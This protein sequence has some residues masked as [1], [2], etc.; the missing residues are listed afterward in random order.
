M[1]ASPRAGAALTRATAATAATLIADDAGWGRDNRPVINVSWHDAKEYAGWLSQK[2]GKTY[3]LL[4][5]AEWEYA[6]RAGSTT[7]FWWGQDVGKG[8]A[9]CNGCG[10]VWDHIK[11][12]RVGSFRPNDFGLYDTAGNVGEWVE[13]CSHDTSGALADRGRDRGAPTDGSP[14]FGGDCTYRDLRG[15]SWTSFPSAVRSAVHYQYLADSWANVNG[16]RVARAPG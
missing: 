4:S 15:G 10:S 9:N 11:T 14:W 1:P 16:F 6:A 5:A 7:A 12:A 13:D 3:R 8:N 2:T